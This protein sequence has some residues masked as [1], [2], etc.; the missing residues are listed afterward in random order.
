[1]MLAAPSDNDLALVT[2]FESKGLSIKDK[3]A[4]G[5]TVADYA[6]KSGKIDLIEKMQ[7]NSTRLDN[8][9]YVSKGAEIHKA[10]GTSKDKFLHKKFEQ[11]NGESTLSILSKV[12]RSKFPAQPWNDIWQD[13]AVTHRFV[14][15]YWHDRDMTSLLKGCTI[16]TYLGCDW[17][18][19]PLHLPST[20]EVWE[21]I[22]QT[23]PTRM[24][25]LGSRLKEVVAENVPAAVKFIEAANR[26]SQQCSRR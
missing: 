19:V 16:P 10:D 2:Y 14:D 18:N 6:A 4:H 17:E 23:A 8:I 22:H 20:F 7:A 13:I 1:M 11:L 26:V 12:M 5:R 15:D 3:D 25:M 9:C 21:A 24:G